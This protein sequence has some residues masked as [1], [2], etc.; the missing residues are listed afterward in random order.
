MI[1][2]AAVFLIPLIII[3]TKQLRSMGQKIA[4][5]ILQASEDKL[6]DLNNQIE[7]KQ[8][9]IHHVIEDATAYADN[10]NAEKKT[11]LEQLEKEIAEKKDK[12]I[13]LS[14]KVLFQ[15][16]SL[17]EP[18]Y[19]FVNSDCYKFKLDEI[20]Q[21][22]KS[23]IKERIAATG[24]TDWLVNN[25]KR[26]GR[27]MVRDTQKLLLR[28]FNSEC[29]N[30]TGKVKYN[31]FNSCKKRIMNAYE[32]IS[33][34]GQVMQISINPE[35]YDLKIQEL[36]LAFEYKQMKQQEKEH[37]R[38]VR[39]RLREEA[40]LQKEIEEERLKVE[41]EKIHY[42]NALD[43][44]RHQYEQSTDG[45]EQNALRQKI[46]ELEEQMEEINKNLSDIDYREA[47]QRAGYVYVISNIGSFGNN[48]YKI[49]MTRRLDPMQRVY[50]LGDASVPFNFDVHA[51]IFSD[52][53][54]KL[55]AALHNA[56]DDKK[57]N[58]IN[59]RREFFNV[60]LDEIEHVVKENFDGTVEFTKLPEA[61]Q[62]R[63]SLKMKQAQ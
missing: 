47:N 14:E 36:H 38:E 59:T 23:M 21:R 51:I 16:F 39:A 61:E 58:L 52:D 49:G 32:A 10:Q 63:E 54:P 5:G 30:V 50:E 31:N 53:A 57:L 27:K 60:S 26:E 48:I 25:N 42:S 41:K 55:E 13:E 34:L 7:H 29:E 44:A 15:D 8:D 33:K 6:K 19:D 17:Y 28:S 62:Y 56:F 24:T 37:Q 35:Y 12:L 2:L 4:D 22:Q 20:R 3:K 1:P 45:K 40:A 46:N 9:L 43:A 11:A 18:M